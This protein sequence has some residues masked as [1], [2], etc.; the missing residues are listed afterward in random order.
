MKILASG[1]IHGDTRL[2]ERL[3]EQ[4]QT[5][6]VDL[7]I[8]CGDLT[9]AEQSTDG[10][11]GPFVKRK[12]K[13]ILIPGNHETI[14]TADFL[15]ELYGA[16]NLHGYGITAGDVGIFGC[17]G[18]NIGLFKLSEKD[19]FDY[20][21]QGFDRVKKAKKTIMVTH[22]HPDDSMMEKF[23]TIFPGSSGV[24]KAIKEFQPDFMLCS[25]VHE[26][27]GIEEMIGKTKVINV[28]KKGKIINI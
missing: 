10:I 26:A 16:T 11:V 4:A 9:Y 15:A 22:V 18:A 25:H 12:Q 28:G 23:T 8:L 2:A 13:V 20:L 3:A 17:G 24:T 21:R 5:E 27:E 1:D 14:A 6:K 19:I 7:V